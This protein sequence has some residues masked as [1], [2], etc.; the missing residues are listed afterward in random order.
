MAIASRMPSREAS[1]E[2]S[3]APVFLR[4]SLRCASCGYEIASYRKV[5][6]CP[7]CHEM[8]WDPAPWRPFTGPHP[9]LRSRAVR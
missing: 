2:G 5:P 9:E 3:A 7:M 4:R 6:P 1:S 8:C